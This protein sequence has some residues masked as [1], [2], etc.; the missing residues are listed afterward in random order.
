MLENYK[1]KFIRFSNEDV[2]YYLN[3]VLR[4]IEKAISDIEDGVDYE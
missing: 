4:T 2:S 1:I 3:D